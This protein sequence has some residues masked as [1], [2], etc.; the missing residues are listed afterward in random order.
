VNANAGPIDL[1]VVGAGPAGCAA[2]LR[3]LQLRAE[4]RVVLLDAAT[5]PRDKACG[6][7]VAGQ[8]VHVLDQLDLLDLLEDYQPVQLLNI[9]G[10]SGRS[11]CAPTREPTY[12]VPRKVFDARLLAATVARGA[13]VIQ[14]RVRRLVTRDGHVE[15]DGQLAAR[16]VVGAD[17][18]NSVVRRQLGI[19]PN[20]GHGMAIAIR[21]YTKAPEGSPAL[22]IR[23]AEK[24]CPAYAW[25]FPIGDGTANIG[26]G[27]F[28][29][30][31]VRRASLLGRLAEELGDHEP[32]GADTLRAHHLPLS[33]ARPA[34]AHGRVL[35]AGDAASLVNP[36]SGEGIYYALLSGVLAG[37]AAANGEG[38]GPAYRQLLRTALGR[39]H[40]HIGLL[41]RL[42]PWPRFVDALVDASLRH[43]R[44]FESLVEIGLGRG[45]VAPS[46]ALSVARSLCR[47]ALR[48][49]P[50]ALGT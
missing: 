5:F 49:Q 20:S 22:V 14:H 35:L 46:V 34:P 48:A 38:A 43:G 15:I 31:T 44:V 4:A 23:V 29:S 39:H 33:T 41:T 3:L 40:R 8:A 26:F 36:L 18:A 28:A 45:T 13:E 16:V 37:E 1:A 25:S 19:A 27:Q 47:P 9:R 6:D 30:G 21:G 17:G 12:V 24:D 10:P 11:V 2:A 42:T 7:A 50:Q 32:A